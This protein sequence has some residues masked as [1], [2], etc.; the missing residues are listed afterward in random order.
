[1]NP[2]PIKRISSNAPYL[3]PTQDLGGG[4]EKNSS[5]RPPTIPSKFVGPLFFHQV[6]LLLLAL[7]SSPTFSL[8]NFTAHP[9]TTRLSQST[10]WPPGRRR[11]PM[12][13]APPQRRR[14]DPPLLLGATRWRR[15]GPP[16]HRSNVDELRPCL[17]VGAASVR[18]LPPSSARRGAPDLPPR[19]PVRAACLLPALVL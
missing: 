14:R 4:R 6:P 16:Q 5:T 18:S 13:A 19:H 3:N 11:L 7:Y 15:S 2:S 1:M 12:A 10:A 9:T 8:I 17:Y